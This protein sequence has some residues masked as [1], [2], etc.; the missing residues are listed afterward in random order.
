MAV[1]G[2]IIII[3]CSLA[4]D[5]SVEDWGSSLCWL[6][7]SSVSLSTPTFYL[8]PTSNGCVH[9][10]LVVGCTNGQVH[11]LRL[12]LIGEVG[13]R[14]GLVSSDVHSVNS[15]I[16]V[17]RISGVTGVTGCVSMVTTVWVR[18]DRIPVYSIVC[19]PKVRCL[20]R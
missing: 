10:Q 8:S 4:S 5:D 16:G 12:K 3:L 2:P 14:V 11:N 15:N 20:G 1:V 6:P 13:G 17:C 18:E 7:S 19:Q 9:G